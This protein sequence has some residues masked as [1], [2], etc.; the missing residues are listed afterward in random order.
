MPKNMKTRKA[1]DG[2]NYPYTSPDLVIDPSGK[3]VTTKFNELE[4]KMKK[5]GST[6]IDDT[7]TTTDKTWS[8]SKIDSQFKDIASYPKNSTELQEYFLNSNIIKVNKDIS[9]T[10]FIINSNKILTSDTQSVIKIEDGTPVDNALIN[11]KNKSNITIKNIIFD[12]NKDNVTGDA[13]SGTKF[14]N[15]ENS[16]H[17]YITKNVFKNNN[18]LAISIKNS[19]NIYI[20]ENHFYDLDCNTITFGGCSNIYFLKNICDGGTSEMFSIY[21]TED[22]LDRDIIIKNNICI[23]KAV[24]SALFLKYCKNIIFENNLI[25]NTATG[26]S[27]SDQ[28]SEYMDNINILNNIFENCNIG[29]RCKLFSNSIISNN[30]VENIRDIGIYLE[31]I[32]Q[33]KI[34]NNNVNN[35]AQGTDSGKG[36]F[37]IDN[38]N[39]IIMDGNTSVG[40][41]EKN[42]YFIK[43]VKSNNIK[44]NNSTSF[45]DNFIMVNND[46]TNIIIENSKSQLHNL[47]TNLIVRNHTHT[48]SGSYFVD[49]YGIPIGGEANFTMR[50]FS[51]IIY[52]NGDRDGY[53][54]TIVKISPSYVGRIIKLIN[55]TGFIIDTSNS[56]SNIITNSIYNKNNHM[57]E[58]FFDGTFW[59]EIS[60][61]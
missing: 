60:R 49:D 45:S 50:Y 24:G 47:L 27:I 13:S 40:L 12:G 61:L 10:N 34:I 36:D 39:N 44:I 2:F 7:N 16:D 42:E 35:S 28:S 52:I 17:I 58:L 29:I 57:I 15:I 33:T 18:Y 59:R 31:S 20:E 6:S 51:D 22:N 23:N 1:K 37:L 14:I 41:N 48:F 4:D 5:V 21:S 55:K 32:K 8:S 53:T 56:A 3:S 30:M 43:I 25:K 11:I 19:K 38:C 46:N 54:D 26:I 9:G